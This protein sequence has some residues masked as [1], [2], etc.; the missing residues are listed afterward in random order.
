MLLSTLIVLP[1]VGAIGVGFLPLNGG[2]VKTAALTLASD[3]GADG[4]V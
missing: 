2:Q 1:I 3:T 4:S